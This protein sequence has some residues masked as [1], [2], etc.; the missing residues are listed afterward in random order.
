MIYATTTRIV[1]TAFRIRARLGG[2]AILRER[3]VTDTAPSRADVWVHGA[4]VG[5]LTS[6]RPVVEALASD[7][8]VLVTA[9]TETGRDMAA[10]WGVQ[11]RLAPLDMPGALGRFLDAA[12][13]ALQLTIESE[14]WPLRSRILA[15]R[16]IR[17]AMIG[18][19]MSQRS[20]ALW[21][22]L[23]RVIG[24]MLARIEALS[25]QDPHSE[26][27][28]RQLG[29]P[30]RALLPGLDLKLLTPAR[31]LPAA[32][33]PE[34]DGTV[35]AAS[36][37][38]G[39]EAAILDAWL[40]ARLAHP[41]LRLVLAIRHPSRG[42]E[43]AALIAERGLAVLR[44]SE[45]AEDGEVLLADTLGEMDHWYARA[46]ICIVGGSLTDKGGHT[47]W[48]PAAHRCALLHGPHVAN[49]TEAYAALQD[50]DAAR[51]VSAATMADCLA[52]LAGNPATA[53]RMGDAARAVLIAR[54]GDPVPLIARLHDLAKPA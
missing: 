26:A 5:E 4:S 30:D 1:E 34:R 32:D 29:L 19:R 40:T 21:S 46:A 22:R 11:S 9:N 36:T 24:P 18:A 37:H 20:A 2:S 41:D 33:S 17:Q 49:F 12:R 31:I 42:N 8:T 44:R 35:L 16:G 28:L 3:L 47:P 25:A 39:E 51:Q 13:P 7:L 10:G 15:E 52:G 48:E 38:E 23:P 53:H 14:F 6:A 54:A 45:G 43:V 27:R 50:A